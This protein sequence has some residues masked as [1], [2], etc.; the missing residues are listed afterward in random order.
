MRFN[1]L[2]VDELGLTR[3]ELSGMLKNSDMHIVNV[4]DEVEMI[5][6]LRERKISFH[7]I[8]WTINS[9][10]LKDFEAIK[11]LKSK[12]AY[13]SIPVIIVSKFTD[14]KYIIK[15]IECGAIEYIAKPYDEESVV[16]KIYK[17]LGVPLEKSLEKK[18]DEYIVTYNFSEML[19]KEIKAASRGAYPL[20]IAM[21]TIMAS[22]QQIAVQDG[23]DALIN[24]VNKVVRTRLRETDSSFLYGLNNIVVLLPFADKSGAECVE[25]K[26]QDIFVTHSMIRQRNTGYSLVTASVTFPDDGKIKGKLLEKLGINFTAAVDGFKKV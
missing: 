17:I 1:I 12:E 7:A 26:L 24:M 16:K 20:T 18:V 10:D 23:A 6:V 21:A 3:I 9:I 25:K 14:K 15:A 8:V 2:S 13:K 11:V 4:A 22:D 19:N 5:N